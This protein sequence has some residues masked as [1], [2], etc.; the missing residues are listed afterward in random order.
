M[1]TDETAAAP[2]SE[3]LRRNMERIETLTQ[4]LVSSLAL[5]GPVNPALNAP[6]PEFF[7]KAATAYMTEMMTNPARIVEQQ[8]EYWGKTFA[9]YLEAQQHRAQGRA[10]SPAAQ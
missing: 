3:N 7:A 4:R 2:A 10:A 6:G 5:T 8:V 9:H 1:A